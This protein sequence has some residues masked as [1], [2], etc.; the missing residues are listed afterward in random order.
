MVNNVRERQAEHAI[1]IAGGREVPPTV[2][3][4]GEM[5]IV[6]ISSYARGT[7]FWC[8]Q[9]CVTH[10]LLSVAEALMFKKWCNMYYA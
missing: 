1:A 5:V 4:D 8:C 3:R 9:L 7:C 2:V 6:C 10:A